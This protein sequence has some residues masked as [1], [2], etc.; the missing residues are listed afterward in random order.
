M[1]P[2]GDGSDEKKEGTAQRGGGQWVNMTVVWLPGSRT[3]VDCACV[4]VCFIACMHEWC[5]NQAIACFDSG[6][7]PDGEQWDE[8]TK[9]RVSRV[10]GGTVGCL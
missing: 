7:R 8:H 3:L 5:S 10:R 9:G 6:V 4:W 1:R 2:D